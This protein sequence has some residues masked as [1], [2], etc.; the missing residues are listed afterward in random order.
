MDSEANELKPY[1]NVRETAKLLAVHENTIRNWVTSG[2][3]VSSRLHG[4][5]AHRFARDEV[6]RVLKS[7]GAKASSIAP[8]LRVDGELVTANQLDAWAGLDDAKGAFPELMRRLLTVTPGIT[9]LDI[10][11]HEGGAAHGWDGTATST[12][13]PFLPAGELRFE[14]GTNGDVKHKAD[15]DYANRLSTL[16]GEAGSSFVFAT[17][18]NWPSAKSWATDKAGKKE[19]AAVKGI[20]SHLLEGW[21]QATP[22]VHYWISERLGY[23]PRDAQ[24]VEGWWNA[25]RGRTTISLPSEFFVAGRA[26]EAQELRSVLTGAAQGD[27]TTTIQVPW[28]DEGVAFIYASLAQ[29]NELLNRTMVVNDEAAWK[30]LADS[31]TPLVLIPLFHD[32]DVGTVLSRGHRVILVAASDDIVQNA[33]KIELRKIDNAAARE[34]LKGEVPDSNRA[35][36]LVALARRSMPALIRRI[37]RESRFRLP[38]WVRNP[39]QAAILAPLVLAGSWTPHDGDQAI[40]EKLTGQTRDVIERLLKG[41]SRQ[42]DAPFV[43]SGGMWRLASPAEAALLLLPHLT[44]GDTQRWAEVASE[45]LL[46]PDPYQ[47]MD[48]V[49]RMTASARG[50]IPA[51][52]GTLA[53]GITNSLAL[54][55]A[56]DHDLPTDLAMQSRVDRIVRTLLE[57]ANADESG[58][59]WARLRYALPNLAEASPE[60]FQD[61][62]ELDLSRSEPIIRTM[63]QDRGSDTMFG[64]SSPHPSL[65]WAIESLC[66]SPAYFGRAADLLARLC[67]LDPGGR[68]SNRPIESLQNVAAGWLPQSGATVDEKVAVIDRLLRR[69]PDVGWNLAMGVWPTA[70]A[71]AFPPHSPTYRDW[72]PARQSV[73]WADWGRF[74]HELVSL[75]LVAADGDFTRWRDLIPKIDDLPQDERHRAIEKLRDVAARQSW[76]PEERYSVWEVLSSEADRHEEYAD[77]AWAMPASDVA[78]FRSIANDLAPAQDPRRLSNLFDWRVHVPNLKRGEEGFEAEVQRLQQEALDEVLAIGQG[79]LEQLTLD[80]KTPHTI[81]Q[82]LAGMPNAPEQEVLAWL[83]SGEPNLVQASLVYSSSKIAALGL[84]WLVAALATPALMESEGREVLMAAVPFTSAFW[85]AIPALGENLDGAYWQRAQH[86]GAPEAERPEAVRLLVLHGRSWEAI[87]LLSGMLHDHQ[88]PQLDLVKEVFTALL[89]HL[90]P[91]QDPTMTGYYVGSLL[92][93]MEQHAPEDEG[94]PQYEFFFFQ[95]L[96]D[97][98]PSRA[99]YRALGKDPTDFVNMV[100]AIFRGE[101]ESKRSLTSQEQGFA[102][103]S[104]SVLREWR[105]VPGQADDGTVD[106]DHLTEWVRAARLALSDSGRGSIGDEQIGQVLA[107]S[108]VGADGVWPAEA[109]REI[110]ENIGNTHLDTGLHIGKTNQRGFTTRGVFDGGTQE[111]ELEKEYRDMASK[112]ATQWPRTARILRGIADSYQHDARRQDAEAERMGDDG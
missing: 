57:A 23:R 89:Q 15:E 97:H 68:L 69:Q 14:F 99:L 83:N 49:Q 112:I 7:R 86:Y 70:H 12:G 29:D 101:G 106:A 77:S 13:S 93:Y 87:A 109:V 47:G 19:F 90:E 71:I 64:P 80:V 105:T 108:S 5:T 43:R 26:A 76:T 65:Q 38:D 66:W 3:L 27:A 67:A 59:A 91:I 60:I 21:L 8:A 4:T 45:V 39:E 32:P 36:E 111:R 81:G 41:L 22:P 18:R 53:N 52:S 16:P 25:F 72:T 20:D 54:A 85:T 79:S 17:P 104:F 95:L 40:V 24:T 61:A 6:L 50:T 2:I 73:T 34:A 11:A 62:V 102:N 35:G 10:R 74:L 31:T 44:E 46:A 30:R 92:E 42:P 63:F 51:F 82:L 75:V 107:G 28:R 56:S 103:L 1:L 96:H 84:P 37:G 58:E 100:N 88:A 78:L 55:A 48:T 33:K 9:N 98:Q 110:V 94:L